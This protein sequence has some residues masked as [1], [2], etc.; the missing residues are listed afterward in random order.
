MRIA[1]NVSFLLLL[2]VVW[3]CSPSKVRATDTDNCDTSSNTAT[4]GAYFENYS[5]AEYQ[6]SYVVAEEQDGG[7]CGSL[8]ASECDMGKS[9]STKECDFHVECHFGGCGAGGDTA[10]WS[11]S[12]SCEGPLPGGRP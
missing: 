6:N 10:V 3:V 5:E 12:C 11:C 8:C 7:D 9:G 2:G 4:I 1:R